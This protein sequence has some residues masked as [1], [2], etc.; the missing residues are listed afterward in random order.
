M[1]LIMLLVIQFIA[2][3]QRS[4]VMFTVGQT[5]DASL[6]KEVDAFYDKTLIVPLRSAWIWGKYGQK[7]PVKDNNVIRFSTYPVLGTQVIALTEGVNPEPQQLTK[8]SITATVSLY[9]GYI[10]LTEECDIYRADPV[11]A[12]AQ[13]RASWQAVESCD[14]IVRDNV[15][16]GTNVAWAGTATSSITVATKVTDADLRKLARAMMIKKTPFFKPMI[17]SGTGVGS[18]PINNAW[19]MFISP[20][21]LYDL[22]N[23]V[24]GWVTVTKYASQGGVEE[25]EV[26]SFGYFRMLMSTECPVLGG[27]TYTAVASTGLAQTVEAGYI[28]VHQ[29]LAI[30]PDAYGVVDADGG[31]K[32]IR[33]DKSAIGGPLELFGTVG[34]KARMTA[35]ILDD[36]RMYRYEVAV[37]A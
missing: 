20:Q 23:S 15:Y 35:K 9:G 7:R 25:H 36:N 19:M 11:V 10:E 16:G 3:I 1:H 14:Q 31:I 33:K 37:T 24:T 32:T 29:C 34:W 18:S 6:A 30:A 13:E 26:G 21:V 22:E 28:D 12:I 27:T 2:M 4:I 8:S 17:T 5:T